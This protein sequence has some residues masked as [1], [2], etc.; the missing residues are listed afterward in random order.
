MSSVLNSN[1]LILNLRLYEFGMQGLYYMIFVLK[2][3]KTL[4]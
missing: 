2:I 4:G 1:K 3:I